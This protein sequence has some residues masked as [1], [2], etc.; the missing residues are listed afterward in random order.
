MISTQ[1]SALLT[2]VTVA[3]VSNIQFYIV[4]EMISLL[5]TEVTLQDSCAVAQ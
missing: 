4:Q 5:C 1:M 3:G 2:G